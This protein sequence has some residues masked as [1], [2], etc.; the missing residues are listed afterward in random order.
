VERFA[1]EIPV[2]N[3]APNVVPTIT[4]EDMSTE[5]DGEVEHSGENDV[6][7]PEAPGSMPSGP[8]S[9]IPEWYKVGWREVG[10]IDV[11]HAP[12]GE[13]KDRFVLQA[14][15]KE[16]YYGEWYHNAAI[17]VVS[18]IV[19]HFMTRFNFGWGWLFV[20]LAFCNTYYTTSMTRVRRHARDDIQRELVKT[21]LDTEFESADWINN[22]LDRFWLIYEPVLSQTIIAS[23]DQILSTNCP[24]FLESLRMSTFTLG[25][26]APRIDMVKT[27]PRTADDVVLMDWGISFNPNDKSDLT[28]KQAQDKVNPKIVLSVR[29]GK[30]IASATI[31][32][33]LEDIMFTGVLRVR[34]KLMTTFPHVQLVD[35][36]FTEKPSFDWVL[37]PI[38]GET[39]GFDIGFI[40]GL[41]SFIREMVHSTLSPMMYDPNVFTLNLEQ[42]LSGAPLDTAVGVLQVTVLSA[43]G[44][45]GT[46][47]GGG[48]PDPYV[49]L[50]LFPMSLRCMAKTSAQCQPDMDGDEVPPRQQ[51][52]G[53]ADSFAYGL[54]RPQKGLRDWERVV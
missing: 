38:G 2:D 6:A 41:S 42:L 53:V 39:F 51:P 7:D 44:L 24:S 8:A 17:I 11:Q 20:L 16:Q 40:P 5:P 46:K 32:I 23:V 36:S 10:G 49:S 9:A 1:L 29:V 35:L 14:F 45:K 12:E 52:H 47:I 19:A 50:R 26:K 3:G 43:R 13:E 28:E 37:K 15:I 27:S 22:F 31:P 54:Q 34:M 18:V 48:T 33:L 25:T 30:G 4:I 21:R